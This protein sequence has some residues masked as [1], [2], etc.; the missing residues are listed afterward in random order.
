MKLL[1]ALI[2][3]VDSDTGF[4]VGL[5]RVGSAAEPVS[6]VLGGWAGLGTGVRLWPS[7]QI[8]LAHCGHVC[9]AVFIFGAARCVNLSRFA[10]LNRLIPPILSYDFKS[11]FS[12]EGQLVKEKS[13]RDKFPGDRGRVMCAQL[14]RNSALP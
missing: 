8:W 10:Y 3:H 5:P 2:G 6:G 13:L 4:G 12:V 14:S 11:A 1:T 7:L 9:V